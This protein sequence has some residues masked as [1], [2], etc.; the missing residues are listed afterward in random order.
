MTLSPYIQHLR[1]ALITAE[2][3]ETWAEKLLEAFKMRRDTIRILSSVVEDESRAELRII[4]EQKAKQELQTVQSK[5][6]NKYPGE[7]ERI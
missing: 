1:R 3:K 2:T 5:L 4:R 6:R 7:D